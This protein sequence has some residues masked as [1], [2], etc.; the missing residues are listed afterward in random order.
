MEKNEGKELAKIAPTNTNLSQASTRK[1]EGWQRKRRGSKDSGRTAFRHILR[2]PVPNNRI[3]TTPL[4]AGI[5][6]PP[7][8]LAY[9]SRSVAI[10]FLRIETYIRHR[11]MT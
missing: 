7:T 10:A 9:R 8:T 3:S 1:I 11:K 5:L 6:V 2:Y 4:G